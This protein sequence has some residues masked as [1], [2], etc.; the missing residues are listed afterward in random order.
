MSDRGSGSGLRPRLDRAAVRAH[1]VD[2]NDGIV[3]TAGVVEGLLA[4]GASLTTIVVAALGAMVGGG[5]ALGGMKYSEAADE[6]DAEL[7]VLAEERRLHE[8]QPEEELAELAALYE[9]KGLSP[10]LAR[11]VADELSTTDAL[12]HHAELEYGIT[13]GDDRATPIG[14]AVLAGLAF[15]VGAGL[16]LLVSVLAPAAWRVPLTV[17]AVVAALG[18]TAT[19]VARLGGLRVGRTVL[20]TVVIGL[21]TMLLTLA[22]G[23]LFVL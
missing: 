7:A 18:G 6:Q 9:E 12:R 19:V 10:D 15:M 13:I 17:V 2:V 21:L 11:R 8:L 14:T 3:A 20:R 4:A 1:L 5:V 22:G 16:P 23:S